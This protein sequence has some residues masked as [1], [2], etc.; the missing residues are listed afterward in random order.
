MT[1]T[2]AATFLAATLAASAGWAQSN[3]DLGGI[4]A[5]PDAPVEVTADSLSVNREEG[6]AV[7]SGNVLIGQGEL[8]IS[9][10]EVQVIYS[11]ETGDITRLL[12]SGGV[13]MVTETEQAE[14]QTADYDIDAGQLVMEGD[15][16]LT[17][18][19]SALSAGRMVVDLDTGAA[20]MD[21]R[22]RTVFQQDGN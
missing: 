7:F 20:Q 6:T 19:A 21:G 22:V 12:A 3:V 9:A 2:I 10:A 15:V 5:D 13:T 17:Q 8:R 14:A 16:L 4:S 18:G 11:E 1:R